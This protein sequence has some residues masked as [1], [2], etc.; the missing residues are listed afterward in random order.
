MY[1]AL[2]TD[3]DGS[4][5]NISSNG[6]D[7]DDQTREAVQAAE[8]AGYHIS[9][10]TGRDWPIT[11]PVTEALGIKALCIISGGSA[12]INPV[13]EEIVWEKPLDSGSPNHIIE[14]F[15]AHTNEGN[16][17]TQCEPFELPLKE[18]VDIPD[19]LR[20]LYLIGTPQSSARAISN[21]IN[22]G[23][24]A[25]SHMT[26]SWIGDGFIDV[27]VTHPDATKEHAVLKWHELMGVSIAETICMGDSGN[28][29]PLFNA[30]SLKIAT[31][32]ATDELKALADYIAPN[33]GNHALEHV[34]TKY[35]LSQEA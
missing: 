32:N 31:G 26:P 23:K 16:V 5:V 8:N 2:I 24:I 1:K 28:D 6:S 11:K 3:L 27:H 35:L 7:V 18:L 14:I 4:A 19:E 17:F 10:A 30:A 9:A 33:A 20:Y 22:S 25:V 29:I 21:E 13:T 34:I 15:K 12:I